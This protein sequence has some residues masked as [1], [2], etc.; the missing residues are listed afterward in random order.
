MHLLDLNLEVFVLHL[1]FPQLL[2]EIISLHLDSMFF[3]FKLAF[4]LPRYLILNKLDFIF[5][6][7]FHVFDV[8]HIVFNFQLGLLSHHFVQLYVL[9]KKCN[10]LGALATDPLRLRLFNL[11]EVLGVGRHL[12]V[13]LG[14]ED[15]IL[16]IDLFELIFL[17][18]HLLNQLFDLQILVVEISFHLRNFLKQRLL[19]RALIGNEHLMVLFEEADFFFQFFDFLALVTLIVHF[20]EI[21]QI[22]IIS[23]CEAIAK[24]SAIFRQNLL[25]LD[26]KSFNPVLQELV[27]FEDFSDFKLFLL[28]DTFNFVH[29]KL[30][31]MSFLF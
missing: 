29:L 14:V 21:G 10:F 20:D 31:K 9:L 6:L 13:K 16:V 23:G 2:L 25:I 18:R 4:E 3:V 26:F 12:L 11:L 27:I 24:S 30:L 22:V 1:Q 7:D 28:E 5:L 8:L 19:V 15:L 17:E